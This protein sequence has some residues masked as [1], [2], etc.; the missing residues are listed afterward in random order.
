MRKTRIAVLIAA[1]LALGGLSLWYLNYDSPEAQVK[2]TLRQLC[3]LANKAEQENAAV[4][5]LK[6]NSTDKVFA[7]RCVID[8]GHE[9]ADGTMTPTEITSMLA[10]YRGVFQ[11]VRVETRDVSI[12][13]QSPEEATASFT[14]F[15]K[16]VTRGGGQLDEVRDL[17]CQLEKRDGRWLINRIAI[18]EVL[19]R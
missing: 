2:R 12:H 18:R 4:A 16:G 19:Q 8:V 14:G 5:A 13:I 11:Q 1:V 7:P 9:L 6:I 17:T 15:L 10:R 3:E